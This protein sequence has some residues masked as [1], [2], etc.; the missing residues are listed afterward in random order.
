MAIS[1]Q[2]QIERFVY[3]LER[4]AS[5]SV[6][7]FLENRKEFEE[8]G[9]L[10]IAATLIPCEKYE[11]FQPTDRP[12]WYET[13]FHFMVE[14]GRFEDNHLSVITF[15]YD[16]SLEAFLFQSLKNLYGLDDETAEEQLRK[17]PIIHLYGS[18]GD[19]LTWEGPARGYGPEL[20]E[21]WVTEAAKGIKIVHEVKPTGGDFENALKLLKS[22]VEVIFL[23]F[24][25]H[26]INVQRLRLKEAAQ[27]QKIAHLGR[28]TRW[29][30]CRKG[31]YDGDVN[32]AMRHLNGLPVDFAALPDWDINQFLEHTPCLLPPGNQPVW[33]NRVS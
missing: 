15:N 8:I 32:R 5:P 17:I 21:N 6:D 20:K 23:G 27:W 26:P 3:A 22:A 30:A 10:A 1:R 9:K 25:F 2:H 31:I 29:L 11:A 12:R 33:P 19:R 18:L 4:S 14:G 28:Q 7:F 16:R 24:G 13:L